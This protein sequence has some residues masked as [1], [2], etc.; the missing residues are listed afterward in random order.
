MAHGHRRRFFGIGEALDDGAGLDMERFPERKRP[1]GAGKSGRCHARPLHRS[2]PIA[3]LRGRP[4]SPLQ[5]SGHRPVL[6][7]SWLTASMP[8]STPAILHEGPRGCRADRA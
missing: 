3:D 4:K 7:F 1:R 2:M 6:A 5:V 8:E